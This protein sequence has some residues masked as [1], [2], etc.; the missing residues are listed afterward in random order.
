MGFHRGGKKEAP[1]VPPLLKRSMTARRANKRTSM[2]QMRAAAV[3]EYREQLKEMGEDAV[4]KKKE[5]SRRR[6][7]SW[8]RYVAY[9]FM[10]LLFAG[11]DVIIIVYALKADMDVL[12]AATCNTMAMLNSTNFTRDNLTDLQTLNT[13][14]ALN[15]R[16]M[17]AE[18]IAV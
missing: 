18:D 7:P 13:S 3:Q 2:L 11:I 16:N 1:K 5:R 10:F 8:C 17:S 12:D 15:T 6:I 9:F 14:L 4:M